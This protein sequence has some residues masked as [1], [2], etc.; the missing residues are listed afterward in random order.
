MGDCVVCAFVEVVRML[1]KRLVVPSIDFSVVSHF[2]MP[3]NLTFK[4]L[5]DRRSRGL[6]VGICFRT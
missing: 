4:L 1:L 6:R 2:F 5:H 3:R